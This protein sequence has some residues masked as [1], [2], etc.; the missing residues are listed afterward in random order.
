MCLSLWQKRDDIKKKRYCYNFCNIIDNVFVLLFFNK[1]STGRHQYFIIL[2]NSHLN[3][4]IIL[5]QSTQNI[6]PTQPKIK[7]IDK[8][9]IIK[10]KIPKNIQW[11]T[12]IGKMFQIL[13]FFQKWILNE[14]FIGFMKSVL[15][16]T[17][18]LNFTLFVR[19]S[20]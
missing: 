12:K 4:I 11:H 14:F 7:F 9:C 17:Y 13:F 8:L 16:L 1:Y 18:L 5:Y 2:N 3:T 20:V 15:K 19:K 6:N 10:T